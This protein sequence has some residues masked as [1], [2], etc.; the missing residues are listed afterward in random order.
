MLILYVHRN[1]CSVTAAKH[2]TLCVD[3][4]RRTFISRLMICKQADDC[5]EFLELQSLKKIRYR[6]LND[7]FQPGLCFQIGQLAQG[8][9]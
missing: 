3:R 1:L 4:P 6:L 7:N 9:M 8:Q 2:S 5:L